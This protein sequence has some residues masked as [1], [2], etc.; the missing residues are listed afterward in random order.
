MTIS[1]GII[2]E[3]L[4]PVATAETEWIVCP[5]ATEYIGTVRVCN[6]DSVTITYRLAHTPSTGAA[7]IEDWDIYDTEL[8]PGEVDDITIEMGAGE[9]LRVYASTSNVSFKYSGQ[10]I[11]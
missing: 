1:Y 2:G 7:S 3:A 5:T 6:V 8:E 4:N 11:V 9:T 10:A